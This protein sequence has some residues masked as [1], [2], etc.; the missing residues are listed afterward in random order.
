[1][2]PILLVQLIGTLGFSIALPFLVFLV[3]DFGGVAWT[4]GLLGAAYSAAQLVGAPILGRWSDRAGRR[5]VLLVSQVGT[6]V[7][8]LIFAVALLLPLRSWGTVGGAT[9]SL[10]LALVFGARILDG[11]TGGNISVANAYVAD[12]TRGNTNARGVVFGRMG[13]ASSVGFTLGP[14]IAGVLGALYE[15]YLAP[16]LAAAAISVVCT[17]LIFTLREPDAPCPDGPPAPEA[18]SR[19]MG[20]QHRRCDRP[21][22]KPDRAVLRQPTVMA[23][24]VAV[25]VL[26][27]GFNLFYA[28]FPVYA[29][30]RVGWSPA[31]MGL[32]FSLMSGTMF[33][34]Q[35][36][37]LR[38]ASRWWPPVRVFA[39]GLAGLIIAFVLFALPQSAALY[40][41]ALMFALGNGIAW[42]TFQARL[43]GAAPGDAQGTVQGASTSAGSLAS[44]VGLVAGG[45]LYPALG[46]GLFVAGAGMLGLVLL[47]SR[48]LF[49]DQEP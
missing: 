46:V 10:P 41:G 40:V 7:A 35:G 25:F 38:A 12:I 27:L 8:W 29:T 11:L 33:I 23:L 9:L 43:A 37:V 22:P 1:M 48:R 28:S 3:D 31:Q 15:G 42:P 49:R 32:F 30:D 26:F 13:M 14:A 39:V 24:I 34:A 21:E 45:F 47:A 5:P 36:P 6:L 20:Q 4:F 16:V 19:V 2:A 18:V 17:G 44:I